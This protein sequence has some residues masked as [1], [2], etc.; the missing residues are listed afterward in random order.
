MRLTRGPG[1]NHLG[2]FKPGTLD[3]HS[4][5]PAILVVA[6]ARRFRALPSLSAELHTLARLVRKSESPKVRK[7]ESPEARKSESPKV[8]K[9][10]SPKVRQSADQFRPNFGR[11][12]PNS[13]VGRQPCRL[14][15]LQT[16]RLADLQRSPADSTPSRLIS[17]YRDSIA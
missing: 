15:D 13:D 2:S 8:R 3:T 5:S 10:E 16:C 17:E 12:T 14:A 6:G 9:S 4:Q 11:R 1:M 7:S